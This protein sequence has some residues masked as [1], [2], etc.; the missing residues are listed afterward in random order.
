M[1]N[2]GN[3]IEQAGKKYVWCP[4][5]TSKDGSIH[6]LYMPSPHN[7]DAW[8]AHKADRNKKF[9]KKRFRDSNKSPD[10]SA[11]SA[12]KSKLADNKLTLALSDKLTSALV[13]QYHLS[14]TKAD[15]LFKTAYSEAQEN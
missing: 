8:V 11:G 7:H 15:N 6:G 5:H 12:K 4:H 13:T 1:T 3:T 9:H 14:Q 10:T 2:K